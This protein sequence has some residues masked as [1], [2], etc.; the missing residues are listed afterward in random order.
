M[1]TAAAGLAAIN[2]AEA[3]MLPLNNLETMFMGRP[4]NQAAPLLASTAS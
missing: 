1:V 2:A 4:P 3:M